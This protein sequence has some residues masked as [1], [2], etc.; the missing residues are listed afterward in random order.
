MKGHVKLELFDKNG[1][2]VEK[3]EDHNMMTN[4]LNE[5][6]LPIAETRQ[7]AM[8]SNHFSGAN[9]NVG[10]L[11]RLFGTIQLFEEPLS[12][13]PNDFLP[14]GQKII[15]LS[16]YN[17]GYSGK[18]GV[19]G[20]Y[21]GIESGWLD[22]NKTFKYVYD[23]PTSQGNGTI[24]S[25]ALSP[26]NAVFS[27]VGT[28]SFDTNVHFTTGLSHDFFTN[29]GY[30]FNSG[31]GVNNNVTTN[32]HKHTV[33]FDYENNYEVAVLRE[34]FKN[35][36]D[37]SYIGKT[38]KIPLNLYQISLSK[39]EMGQGIGVGNGHSQNLLDAKYITLKNA[40]STSS[41]NYGFINFYNGKIY[42]CYTN[43][44]TWG[45]NTSLI[46]TCMNTDTWEESF[47]TVTN[48]TGQPIYLYSCTSYINGNEMQPRSSAFC[49]G[50]YLMV[51]GKNNRLYSINV[52]DNT[53]VKMIMNGDN[54]YTGITNYEYTT[55]YLGI[56]DTVYFTGF[57]NYTI[58][59]GS[60]VAVEFANLRTG[61]GGC[62]M[63]SGAGSN[64]FPVNRYCSLSPVKNHP[65]LAMGW[66]NMDATGSNNYHQLIHGV[67]ASLVLSTKMNLDEPVVK[68]SDLSMKV[69][70]SLTFNND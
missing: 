60:S 1:S 18:C 11:H 6:L 58:S 7:C 16:R 34:V 8:G 66:N 19:Y 56:N 67:L 4:F 61:Q 31:E 12:Q 5:F 47:I 69:T 13:D 62:S 36:S 25:L 33:Y 64:F 70:Y 51:V 9:L 57:N 59:E 50:E 65:C 39:F 32:I 2:L 38:S 54:E 27:G 10:W 37:S 22:D 45:V 30:N 15:G 53:D 44:S 20:S 28:T 21:N 23:F 48:T 24:S 17:L 14:N 43:S 29:T 3:R 63:N 42:A 26:I 52:S 35:S 41:S 55:T 46:V 40:L 49:T 68:T